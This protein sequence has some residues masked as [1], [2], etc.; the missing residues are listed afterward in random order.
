M[1]QRNTWDFKTADL[2]G[3]LLLTFIEPGR[4]QGYWLGL[5]C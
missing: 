4:Q 1:A 2:F 3:F 5:L